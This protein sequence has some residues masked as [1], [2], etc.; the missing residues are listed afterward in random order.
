MTLSE[1]RSMCAF[2]ARD[3]NSRASFAP[4]KVIC[5]GS[6]LPLLMTSETESYQ[7]PQSIGQTP[8]SLRK[9][10][11]SFAVINPQELRESPVH[12]SVA[13]QPIISFDKLNLS[14]Y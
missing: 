12:G 8:I 9:W 11:P 4:H 13:E 5:Q 6:A 2:Y 3:M 7:W 10:S 1:R 14:F